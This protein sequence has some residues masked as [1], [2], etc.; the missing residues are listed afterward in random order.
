MS[1]GLRFS[2]VEKQLLRRIRRTIGRAPIRLVLGKE[3]GISPSETAPV[4]S[5]VILIRDRWTLLRLP[6]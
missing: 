6:G 5:V 2:S 4:A 1:N 3:E